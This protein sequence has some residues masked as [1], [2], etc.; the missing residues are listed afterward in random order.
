MSRCPVLAL[1]LPFIKASDRARESH[2][3]RV[4]MLGDNSTD[5]V[6]CGNDGAMTKQI[7][8][9]IVLNS[10]LCPRNHYFDG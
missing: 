1:V 6:D 2:I 5:D 7:S 8:S 9:K 3:G 10:T 4:M